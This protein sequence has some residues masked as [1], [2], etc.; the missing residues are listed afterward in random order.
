MI[1]KH[2]EKNAKLTIATQ[3][4]SWDEVS[5]FGIMSINEDDEII[6]FTEKPKTSDSNLASMGLYLFDFELLKS[7]L[8]SVKKR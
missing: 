5:R 1:A 7:L 4:V 8:L 6:K 3:K 2:K